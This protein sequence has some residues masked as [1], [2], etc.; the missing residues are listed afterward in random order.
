MGNN[1]SVLCLA[2]GMGIVTVA[3]LGWTIIDKLN[4]IIAL[5]EAQ[6]GG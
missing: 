3:I 2:V 6:A 1:G 5:L 4:A